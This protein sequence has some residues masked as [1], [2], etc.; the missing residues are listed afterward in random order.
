MRPTAVGPPVHCH[1]SLPALAELAAAVRGGHREEAAVIVERCAHALADHASP[2]LRALL[3][4]ARGLL[5]APEDTEPHFRTALA[6]PT[7]HHWPFERAQTLLDLAEWLRRRRRVAEARAPPTD[8]L[9]TFRRLGA[10]P[11][12]ERAR[13][14]S[15]AA[16]LAVTDTAPTR[17]PHS[18]R[19]NS[20]SSGWPPAA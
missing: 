4:R 12:I 13:A 7:T 9:E 8:A 5:A 11:W 15:R 18:P 17:W 19:N 3:G 6:D 2:R 1:A 16:G 14:E 20:R 10:R